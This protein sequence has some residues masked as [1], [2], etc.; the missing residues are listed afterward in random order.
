MDRV[1]E[2]E[3][4]HGIDQE[5]ILRL[6]EE[7]LAQPHESR[8]LSSRQILEALDWDPNRY[9]R[10]QLS[11]LLRGLKEDGLIEVCKVRVKTISDRI[12]TVPGYRPTEKALELLDEAKTITESETDSQDDIS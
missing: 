3:R 7:A 12:Q 6:L 11:R 8:G 10:D 1:T 4:E 5:G 2:Y 9:R